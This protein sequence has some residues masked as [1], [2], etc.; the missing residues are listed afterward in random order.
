MEG[1]RGIGVVGGG[2]A[3]LA[4]AW[5]LA[6][7][8]ARVRVYEAVGLGGR[9]RT[10]SVAEQ[11]AD[12]AVQLVSAGYSRFLELVAAVGAGDLLV[13][14]PGRDALWRGGRA[15]D[16]RYGSVASMAASGALPG[17]LKLRLALK[18][19]PFLER[20][21]RV[22]DLN[23]PALAAAAGLD[24]ESIGAWGRRELGDEFVELMVYPLLAAYYGVT[25]EETGAGVFHG[26]A[27]AG[28]RVD[29]LGVR[30]GTGAL[31][32]AVAGW[33]G[34]RG[35]GIQEGAPVRSVE[36]DD[37]GVRL[38][39]G[40]GE[41]VDHDAVV[42][43][44]PAREAARLVPGA[45]WLS[46]IRSRSTATLVLGLERPV[47][48]GWFGLSIP[49]TESPGGAVAAVCVQEE[50]ATGVVGGSGGSLVVVPSP[51]AGEVWAEGEPGQAVEAAVPTLDV[52]L[53]GVR[54]AIR[55]ARLIRF[56]GSTFVPEPGHF[57]RVARFQDPTPSPRV[58]L[59]G[60]Y[61]VA[62]TVEGAVRSGVRA[63]ERLL[64]GAA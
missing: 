26:L 5:R 31:V 45:S 44:V 40:D 42:V 48:P 32:R 22:L 29:L 57:D 63:A 25:P 61:L 37:G 43:A 47:R 16:L 53:P 54:A 7:G 64:S 41:V 10:E 51:D 62:P 12:V 13:P 20:H 59:A 9:L 6:S 27:R 38:R 58:A 14:V 19:M 15:H 33:L 36:A 18:Y 21:A 28:L 34:T 3:G 30:G 49:R 4:A 1:D 60:D 35:V 8:G 23:E 55:E 39:L 52:V 17:R 56:R 46:G 2:P 11:G 24:G 50:K